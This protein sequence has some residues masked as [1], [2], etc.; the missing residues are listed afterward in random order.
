M[1]FNINHHVKVK[2]TDAGIRILKEQHDQMDREIQERGG[3]GLGIFTVTKDEQGYTRFQLWK[4][5]NIFGESLTM[6]NND[7]PFDTTIVIDE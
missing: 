7:V 3:K 6:G 1:E 5:M 4:L 2:L